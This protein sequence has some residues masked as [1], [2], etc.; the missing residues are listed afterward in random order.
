MSY[1]ICTCGYLT[2]VNLGLWLDPPDNVCV[3]WF[4]MEVVAYCGLM[5]F[6]WIMNQ[7][8]KK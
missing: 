2:G 6:I 3:G 5:G 8:L 1:R 4:V 7:I